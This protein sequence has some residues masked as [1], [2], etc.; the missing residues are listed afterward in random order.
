[1]IRVTPTTLQKDFSQPTAV[2][3]ACVHGRLVDEVLDT[4]GAKTG[5]LICLECLTVFPD[6]LWKLSG[7]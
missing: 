5:Q 1:M 2:K 3:K 7:H 6:P 4:K